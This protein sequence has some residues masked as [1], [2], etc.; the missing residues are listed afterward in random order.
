MRSDIKDTADGNDIDCHRQ[1]HK[2]CRCSL[3]FTAGVGK[4]KTA[5]K[6]SFFSQEII[7]N[8]SLALAFWRLLGEN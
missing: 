7:A 6:L 4:N 5:F 8:L 1:F 2:I 3:H